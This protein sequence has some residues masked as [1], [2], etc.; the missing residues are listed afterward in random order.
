MSNF[1]YNHSNFKHL[2]KNSLY[3]LLYSIYISPLTRGQIINELELRIPHDTWIGNDN[4]IHRQVKDK[5]DLNFLL[6]TRSIDEIEQAGMEITP[7]NGG[8]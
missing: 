6:L 4:K 7:L 1:R 8:T 5:H 2:S 3:K